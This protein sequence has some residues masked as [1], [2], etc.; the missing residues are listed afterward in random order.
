MKPCISCL[1]QV[2]K[3]GTR[4]NFGGKTE[5]I[6]LIQNRTKARQKAQ[7]QTKIVSSKE[8][9]IVVIERKDKSGANMKFVF[10]H[11]EAVP[12]C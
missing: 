12:P 10:S 8:K 4:W 7:L 1:D 9:K 6:T 5:E 2:L 3:K 11:K